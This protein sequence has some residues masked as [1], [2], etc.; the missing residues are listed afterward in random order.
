MYGG[1]DFDLIAV[2]GN[3]TVS[4]IPVSVLGE[5]LGGLVSSIGDEKSAVESRASNIPIRVHFEDFT[6]FRDGVVQG[7]PFA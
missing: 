3:A 7:V 4:L 1:V 6:K 2:V 5:N